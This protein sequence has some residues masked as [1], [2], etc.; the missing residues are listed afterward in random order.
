MFC[1]EDVQVGSLCAEKKR[2]VCAPHLGPPSNAPTSPPPQAKAVAHDA[3]LGRAGLAKFL[4]VADCLRTHPTVTGPVPGAELAWFHESHV[5]RWRWHALIQ[6]PLAP[7]MTAPRRRRCWTPTCVPFWPTLRVG[8]KPT[9]PLGRRRRL[10]GRLRPL[11]P[12]RWHKHSP[13]LLPSKSERVNQDRKFEGAGRARATL[14]QVSLTSLSLSRPSGNCANCAPR[15]RPPRPLPRSQW[16]TAAYLPTSPRC[17]VRVR[18]ETEGRRVVLAAGPLS[19]P[20]FLPCSPFLTP[21]KLIQLAS[22][23]VPTLTPRVRP[24]P[25]ASATWPTW[26]PRT[27]AWRRTRHC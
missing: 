2:N 14:T 6:S 20:P 15:L 5:R 24:R 9:S 11:K 3:I 17:K 12:R 8:S 22:P 21:P 18:E 10:G 25:S 1:G 4:A 26:P 7:Q 19:Q 16:P 13:T 27:P 23:P